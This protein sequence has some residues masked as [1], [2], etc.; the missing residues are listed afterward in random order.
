M[1]TYDRMRRRHQ[2][3]QEDRQSAGNFK[4]IYM[5]DFK[6]GTYRLLPIDITGV[7]GYCV[8]RFIIRDTKQ[9]VTSPE[10]FNCACPVERELKRAWASSKAK[11]ETWKEFSADLD[12]YLGRATSY[13][14]PVVDVQDAFDDDGKLIIKIIESKVSAHDAIDDYVFEDEDVNDISH[15]ETG[16]NFK[17]TK[18][19]TGFDTRYK[20]RF[21][22]A[23]PLVDALSDYDVDPDTINDAMTVAAYAF[24]LNKLVP[25]V[26]RTHLADA[27]NLI[28]GEDMPENYMDADYPLPDDVAEIASLAVRTERLEDLGLSMPSEGGEQTPA[29]TPKAKKKKAGKPARAPKKKVVEEEEEEEEAPAPR[30]PKA[31][32]KPAPRSR[33]PKAKAKAK[34]PEIEVGSI[35]RY[36][37]EDDPDDVTEGEV[38]ELLETEDGVIVV[39]STEDGD[40]EVP[41]EEATLVATPEGEA[42]AE[43]EE[44]EAPVTTRARSATRGRKTKAPEPDEDDDDAPAPARRRSRG[45][46]AGSTGSTA[47]ARLR[48]RAGK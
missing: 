26:D 34:A 42:P 12:T 48:A 29:P 16:R 20:V 2:Q 5:K 28:T 38:L 10:T 35:I 24:S 6:K 23:E 33:K 45:G 9:W 14:I 13:Y 36:E 22:D 18:T 4:F 37:D 3:R 43:E 25:A 31:K 32:A 41:L 19:G 44:E 21:Y 15:L 8:K 30:K 27:Y 1:S 17:M 46:G 11:G 7:I 40:F 47:S 39:F